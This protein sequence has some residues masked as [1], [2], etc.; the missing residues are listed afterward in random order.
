MKS[1]QF[2]VHRA[3]FPLV[4]SSLRIRD[5]IFKVSCTHRHPL[6]VV[7]ILRK[8]DEIFTVSRTQSEIFTVSGT[9]KSLEFLEDRVTFAKFLRE[10]AAFSFPPTQLFL[11]IILKMFFFRMMRTWCHR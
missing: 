9:Q 11:R 2:L 4:V 10:T 7:S 6:V 8:G 1:L 5:Q 3:T